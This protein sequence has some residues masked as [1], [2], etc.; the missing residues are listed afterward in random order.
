M[1]VLGG[2]CRLNSVIVVV[3]EEDMDTEVVVEE[4]ATRMDVVEGTMRGIEIM[5][6]PAIME[7]V[8]VLMPIMGVV[9]DEGFKMGN[10]S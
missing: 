5:G 7:E 4:E 6:H 1:R 2:C 8:P 3:E 9:R 10:E